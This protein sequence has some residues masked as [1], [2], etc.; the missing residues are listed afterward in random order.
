MS[1]SCRSDKKM[2][3]GKVSRQQTV[4]LLKTYALQSREITVLLSKNKSIN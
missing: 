4:Q 3:S 2:F 1:E